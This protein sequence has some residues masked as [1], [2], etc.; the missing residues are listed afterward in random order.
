MNAAGPATG[1]SNGPASGP[2][3]GGTSA[4]SI[5]VNG[6]GETMSDLELYYRY[7]P[8]PS[9]DQ[10]QDIRE[11]ITAQRNKPWSKSIYGEH[12]A[13][14]TTTGQDAT[15]SYDEQKMIARKLLGLRKGYS[16]DLSGSSSNPCLKVMRHTNS[17]RKAVHNTENLVS[18]L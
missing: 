4:Q 11:K 2:A 18:D 3:A 5:Q 10:L 17:G 6:A 8:S 1:P 15:L 13:N 14:T 16:A 7:G 12:P 9:K